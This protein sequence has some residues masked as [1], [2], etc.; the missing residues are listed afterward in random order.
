MTTDDYPTGR[1][2]SRVGS[3]ISNEDLALIARAYTTLE[4]PGYA[5]RISGVIG[6]PLVMLFKLMPSGWYQRFHRVAESAIRKTLEVAVSTIRRDDCEPKQDKFHRLICAFSGAGGGFLGLPGLI[7][8]LP[9]ST[10]IMMRSIADIA[11]HEGE[12]VNSLESQIACMEV[13]ALGGR[14]EQDDAADAG[15]YGVRMTLALATSTAA[16]Q[17]ADVG[18]GSSGVPALAC[19]IKTVATRFG[20]PLSEKAAVQTLPVVG[21]AAGVAFNT[22]FLQHFQRMAHGHFTIRRLERKY[23]YDLVK[24]EYERLSQQEK[25]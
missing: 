18:F 3:F 1:L 16:P 2:P 17:I 19:F 12:D 11:R 21:A 7:A 8:E 4:H 23:G 6:T 10:A 22:L 15:Y 13:F 14:T 5:D 9:V 24:R 20:V 25:Q